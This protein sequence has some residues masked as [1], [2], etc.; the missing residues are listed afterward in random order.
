MKKIAAIIPLSLFFFFQAFGQQIPELNQ[1][2]VDYI[3]TQIGKK[4]DKGECWDLAYEVLKRNNCEWDGKYRFGEKIN[5]ETDSVFPGDILQFY[6]VT[7][8]NKSGN[9]TYTE[10]YGKHTAIIYSI[11]GKGIYEIAH[12]NNGY[13]GRKVGISELNIKNKKSGIIE[14]Y[15]PVAKITR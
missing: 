4:V 15:R 5:P 13:S 10:T 9:M 12:Q 7:L 14:F 1:K 3:K 8:K 2:I 6:N 11:K